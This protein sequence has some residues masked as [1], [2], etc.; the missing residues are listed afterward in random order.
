MS[1]RARRRES[2]PAV[3]RAAVRTRRTTVCRGYP[4]DG[5]GVLGEELPSYRDEPFG[6]WV[7]DAMTDTD[8]EATVGYA[9]AITLL[10]PDGQIRVQTSDDDLLSWPTRRRRRQAVTAQR[11]TPATANSADPDSGTTAM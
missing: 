7:D 4:D 8:V 1:S 9:C 2:P 5:D 11:A 6:S 3:P 10:L